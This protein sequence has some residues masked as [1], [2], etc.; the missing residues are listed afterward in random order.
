M[1]TLKKKK[2]DAF[3]KKMQGIEGIGLGKC[4]A[5]LFFLCTSGHGP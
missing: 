4:Q 2:K 1:S 3:G 5:V